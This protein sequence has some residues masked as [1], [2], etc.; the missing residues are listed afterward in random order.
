MNVYIIRCESY[1]DDGEHIGGKNEGVYATKELA[2]QT[3]KDL[4]IWE[5]KDGWLWRNEYTITEH[6]LQGELQI[7]YL[8]EN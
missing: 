3:V 1:W 4:P 8:L 5:D 6:K 2:E 7:D